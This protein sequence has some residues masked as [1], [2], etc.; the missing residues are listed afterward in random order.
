MRAQRAPPPY[1]PPMAPTPVLLLRLWRRLA[2][3]PGGGLLFG[4]LVG[5]MAPYSGGVRPRVL[6]LEPG[7]ARVRI[8]ERRRL[9]N[10][11]R[12]VHAIALANVG[13]LAS[14]LAMIAALPADARGIPVRLEIDYL[15]KARGRITADGRADPPPRVDMEV[16]AMATAELRD[17]GGEVVAL[18]AVTWRLSPVPREA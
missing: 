7:R 11:L 2:P 15:K 1:L 4:L 5:W 10:H 16:D 12:S 14:G 3:L 17:E 18:I 6:H 9:R 13:E 8:R